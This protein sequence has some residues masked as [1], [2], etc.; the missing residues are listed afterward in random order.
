M[1]ARGD[2]GTC[3]MML[4]KF[5]E[6]ASIH[7]EDCA[8]LEKLEKDAKYASSLGRLAEMLRCSGDL[9]E[10]D[11]LSQE[12][13]TVAE[14]SYDRI[15]LTADGY[16]Q[17]LNNAIVALVAEVLFGRANLLE[18]FE[19]HHDAKHLRERALNLVNGRFGQQEA[20]FTAYGMVLGD[21]YVKL[22]QYDKA[23]PLIMGALETRRKQL[24]KNHLLLIAG[25]NKLGKLYCLQGRLD[26]AE[27]LLVSASKLTK[28][29]NVDCG[30]FL[31][32]LAL[33]RSKQGN[34]IALQLY[35]Q[36]LRKYERVFGKDHPVLLPV[37]KDYA[38][39]LISAGDSNNSRICKERVTSIRKKYKID[40][41]KDS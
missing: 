13:V 23:A 14:T 30:E 11:R 9:Q 41:S 35:D 28:N 17:L 32:D 27:P 36:A 10:A 7:R 4:G 3:L 38:D 19:R 34:R 20:F 39:A 26:E 6:A 33:L 1:R 15:D 5:D 24:P 22:A 2:L 12:A 29:W 18:T 8:I 40:E 16:Q 21:S 25:Q 31:A 37:L